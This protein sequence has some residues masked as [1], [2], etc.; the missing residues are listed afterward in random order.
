[1]T[2]QD[3]RQYITRF[4][5]RSRHCPLKKKTERENR[6]NKTEIP[7]CNDISNVVRF[8]YFIKTFF[9]Y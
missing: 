9:F 1:M 6:V 5:L 2:D 4:S 3:N 7:F 8:I